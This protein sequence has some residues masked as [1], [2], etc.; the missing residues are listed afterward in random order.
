MVGGLMT[1]G[2]VEL[3]K[4]TEASSEVCDADGDE[5]RWICARTQ[6]KKELFAARNL[7]NQDYACFLPVISKTVRH[8]R[9]AKVVKAALFPRYLFININLDVQQWRPILGT[10]GVSD[11]VMQDGRPKP[12]P[13]G[14]VETLLS[15]TNV[16]GCADFRHHVK[17]GET[18]RMMSGPF[19]NLVGRLERLDSQGRVAVLLDILGGQRLVHSDATALQSVAA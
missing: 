13:V 16:D 9:K 10:F 12:V 2:H 8:A 15:A 3:D 4:A 5:N 14:V 19:Y 11:L 7:D 17:V 6:P 1:H 18:V